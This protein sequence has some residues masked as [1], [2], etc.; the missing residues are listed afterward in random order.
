MNEEKRK[1]IRKRGQRNL[2][3]VGRLRLVH[4]EA[5]EKVKARV[6]SGGKERAKVKERKVEVREKG[7]PELRPRRPHPERLDPLPI[8]CVSNGGSTERA[9]AGTGKM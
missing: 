6:R 2:V 1:T 3:Q 5:K 9:N 7:R 4:L 8:T